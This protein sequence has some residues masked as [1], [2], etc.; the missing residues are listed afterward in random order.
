[1]LVHKLRPADIMVVA[2]LGDSVT[3]KKKTQQ[4]DW[5]RQLFSF[6]LNSH[7][8]MMTNSPIISVHVN[9]EYQ[10]WT[11]SYQFD[12]TELWTHWS[13]CYQS[14]NSLCLWWSALL[15][16]GAFSFFFNLKHFLSLFTDFSCLFFLC[17]WFIPNYLPL[18]YTLFQ[19]CRQELLLKPKIFS[20]WIEI[21][22]DCRGGRTSCL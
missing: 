5:L 15:C 10:R 6:T 16:T 14:D 1:M 8:Y 21:T 13:V 3:V 4:T 2:A 20:S 18:I 9:I 12:V 7:I 19:L 11:C 17:V 22:Q